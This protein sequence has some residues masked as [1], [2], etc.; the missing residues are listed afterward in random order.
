[1]EFANS[2]VTFARLPMRSTESARERVMISLTTSMQ[3]DQVR[4]ILE[5]VSAAYWGALASALDSVVDLKGL[6]AGER[7]EEFG[8]LAA[9]GRRRVEQLKTGELAEIERALR[10][11]HKGQVSEIRGLV[12]NM[13][14]ENESTLAA[15]QEALASLTAQNGAD[16]NQAAA[17]VMR[18][19]RLAQ[20]DDLAT[21]KYGIRES[22]D[23]LE[24]C[25]TAIQREKDTVILILRDEIRTL[26]RSLEQVK[27]GGSG[28]LSRSQFEACLQRTIASKVSFSA[29]QVSIRNRAQIE[30]QRGPGY[31]EETVRSFAAELQALLPPGSVTGLWSGTELCSI[32]LVGYHDAIQTTREIG[33]LLEHAEATAGSAPLRAQLVTVPFNTEEGQDRLAKRVQKLM[34]A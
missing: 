1:M 12:S 33:T 26:Q 13:K 29:I 16:S 23:R 24:A 2:I 22:A 8:A 11:A 10:D 28:V 6:H 9:R 25:I 21:I 4:S 15:L 20:L 5:Q 31:A 3:L 34:A 30:R 14:A 18:M 32:V 7:R 27:A 19:R 17:E